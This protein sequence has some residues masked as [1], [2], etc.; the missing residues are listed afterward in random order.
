[1]PD[2]HDHDSNSTHTTRRG[3]L[4]LTSRALAV[5]T[6]AAAL[7]TVCFSPAYAADPD[8]LPTVPLAE[9]GSLVMPRF[10]SR[11]Q[12]RARSPKRRSTRIYP[13]R[14]GVA[15]HHLGPKRFAASKHSFCPA[16]VRG[17]QNTHMDDRGWDDI[18]YTYL[19]CVHGYVF[20]GRG[21]GIRTAANGTND[22]NDRYYAVCGLVGGGSAYD[23]ITDQL[24]QGFRNAIAHL[25]SVGNAGTSITGHKTFMA[26]ECPGK[27]SAY[28]SA[29]RPG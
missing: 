25:R 13:A 4:G 18:A 29:M 28:L 20:E 1:M 14:G 27:L 24:I 10:I 9:R 8:E 7:P 22:G 2:H 26:T 21:V 16:Q 19:V 17:I 5:A 15:V 3:F 11:P 12:W 23:P 6:G